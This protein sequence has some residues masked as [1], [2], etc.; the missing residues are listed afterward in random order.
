MKKSVSPRYSQAS[1]WV[2]RYTQRFSTFSRYC[3]RS[4]TASR[5]LSA[6]AG[7]YNP[8]FERPE[9]WTKIST[10]YELEDE[11]TTSAA[12]VTSTHPFLAEAAGT[13]QAESGF[14]KN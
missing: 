6:N 2:D 13:S 4:A 10:A 8:S 12:R 5:S 9:E 7:S 1:A 14:R 11:I 3:R